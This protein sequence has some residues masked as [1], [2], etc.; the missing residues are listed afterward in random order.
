MKVE[1]KDGYAVDFKMAVADCFK[2]SVAEE[3]FGAGDI[4]YNDR[5]AYMSPWAEAVKHISYAFQV[6]QMTGQEIEYTILLRNNDSNSLVKDKT[7]KQPIE[8][9]IHHLKMG[10]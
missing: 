10:I 1:F 7:V 4:I 2:D 3:K 5:R 6:I 9:F 8:E